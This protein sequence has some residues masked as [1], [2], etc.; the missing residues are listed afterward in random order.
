MNTWVV[1]SKSKFKTEEKIAV[2]SAR[3]S[4][5]FWRKR[6]SVGRNTCSRGSNYIQI[7]RNLT[8]GGTDRLTTGARVS[9]MSVFPQCHYL[10]SS[11]LPP[12]HRC[13]GY[14]TFSTEKF[15]NSTETL[16]L[17]ISNF[18]TSPWTLS[19]PTLQPKHCPPQISTRLTVCHLFFP[20]MIPNLHFTT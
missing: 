18:N 15:D 10:K 4:S 17:K 11:L 9:T 7:S 3:G 12:F 16:V 6:L 14:E 19:T 13:Y 5:F 2:Q 8:I 1:G 20:P